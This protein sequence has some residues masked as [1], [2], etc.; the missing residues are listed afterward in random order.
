[1]IHPFFLT[2]AILP[3]SNDLFYASD[4]LSIW[5]NLGQKKSQDPVL[6]NKISDNMSNAQT[7]EPCL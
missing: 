7:N 4:A 1:M 5:D 6:K 2:N 3:E